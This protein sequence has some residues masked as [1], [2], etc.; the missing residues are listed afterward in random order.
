MHTYPQPAEPKNYNNLMT[1]SEKEWII[2]IQMKQMTTDKPYIDDYYAMVCVL[3]PNRITLTHTNQ[4]L[5][6]KHTHQPQLQYAAAQSMHN[7]AL[8]ANNT[9]LSN[10][11]CM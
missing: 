6:Q 8:F 9:S 3:L 5:S 7:P 4:A 10:T 2:S 11:T 1:Q